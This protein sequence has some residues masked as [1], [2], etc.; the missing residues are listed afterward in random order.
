[1]VFK[2]I[3]LFVYVFFVN[4]LNSL[5][6]FMIAILSSRFCGSYK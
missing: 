1:M 2:F 5:V 3:E 4:S 6:K